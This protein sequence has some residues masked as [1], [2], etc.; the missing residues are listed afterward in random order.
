MTSLIKFNHQT[1]LGVFTKSLF[2]EMLTT[3]GEAYLDYRIFLTNVIGALVENYRN[4]HPDFHFLMAEHEAQ[5]ALN[6]LQHDVEALNVFKQFADNGYF[7]TFDERDILSSVETQPLHVDRNERES[8]V[9]SLREVATA[10][11]MKDFVLFCGPRYA[12]ENADYLIKAAVDRV[13]AFDKNYKIAEYKEVQPF[14]GQVVYIDGNCYTLGEKFKAGGEGVLHYIQED[15]EHNYLAKIYC[16]TEVDGLPNCVKF[17]YLMNER[18]NRLAALLN[19]ERFIIQGKQFIM[20]EKLIFDESNHLI[21]VLLKNV[22]RL[23]PHSEDI[24]LELIAARGKYPFEAFNRLEL[25]DIA[26]QT[27]E[28]IKQLHDRNIIIGDINMRNFL[29]TGTSPEDL[30][31]TL[32]DLD[33]CQ[34]PGF[35]S[36]YDTP[37]YRD[38]KWDPKS[39]QPR[40]VENEV[41]SLLVMLFYLL[42]GAHPFHYKDIKTASK[43]AFAINADYQ[44]RMEKRQFP[45]GVNGQKAENTEHL[46]PQQNAH[47]SFSYLTE[48]FKM[49]FYNVF[50]KGYT[51]T[52]DVIIAELK[53]YHAK[54]AKYADT[55]NH[56]QY[57]TF[58]IK[59]S[60][61]VS[62]TCSKKDCTGNHYYTHLGSLLDKLENNRTSDFLYCKTHFEWNNYMKTAAKKLGDQGL[63]EEYATFMDN[64]NTQRERIDIVE[65]VEAFFVNQPNHEKIKEWEQMKQKFND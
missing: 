62:F 63:Q 28:S 16:T 9:K 1:D 35:P 42:N 2:T 65:I 53:K 14:E 18:E 6:E 38:P 36:Y 8:V 48:S 61:R 39:G 12:F 51:T 31:V 60:Y 45:Y 50:A 15:G 46:R 40:T 54:I 17:H 47:Y 22:Q 56:M 44:E 23:Y 21:G 20:P 43:A 7:R 59:D 34:I 32:I 19:D 64:Y 13:Y 37:G 4:E 5:Q 58:A 30:Q 25:I 49:L 3:T 10:N 52:L 29:V 11:G 26:I 57:E 27:T 55:C 33:G 41:Y 24:S